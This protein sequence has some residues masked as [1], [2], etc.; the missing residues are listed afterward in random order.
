MKKR[1]IVW[2]IVIVIALIGLGIILYNAGIFSPP[3]NC[4]K[5]GETFDFPENQSSKECCAGLKAVNIQDIVSVEEKCYWNGKSSGARIITCS[6]CGNGICEDV[7]SVCG[8]K[9]DCIGKEK[10]DYKT[11]QEFCTDGFDLYCDKMTEGT[12]LDLCNLCPNPDLNFS[13]GI[14]R[15][16]DLDPYSPPWAGILNQTWKDQNTLVVNCY[17]K[18][19]CGGAAITGDYALDGNNL[20]LKYK[21]EV[22]DTVTS[23]M[24][25]HQLVYE[26]PNLDNSINY[27]VFINAG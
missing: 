14:C 7:E 21:I 26:I 13:V 4:I 6:N 16:E 10:S 27:S 12:D 18:T 22:G 9:E 25:P 5:Q 2:I 23:C 8:C 1:S 19:F 15:L 20:T 17:V 3:S 11:V 24:C